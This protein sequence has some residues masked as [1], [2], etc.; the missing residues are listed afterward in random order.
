MMVVKMWIFTV[1]IPRS[2]RKGALGLWV[3]F[4]SRSKGSTALD[5]VTTLLSGS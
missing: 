4:W 5:H 1:V 3:L 2:S